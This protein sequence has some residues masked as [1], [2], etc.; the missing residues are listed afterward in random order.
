MFHPAMGWVWGN[1]PLP[2]GAVKAFR[3]LED[4]GGL[5]DFVG[6]TRTKYVPIDEQVDL[7]LG[8]DLEVRIQPKLMNWEKLDLRFDRDGNVSGWTIRETWEVEL[9]N[10]RE[11]PVTVDIRR[12]FAGDWTIESRQAYEMIDAG[13]V[14]FELPLAAG[15][16]KSFAYA[17]TTNFGANV[18]R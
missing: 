14:K 7:E 3:V 11:I 13:K 9:Q 12:N 4:K 1:E 2:D 6:D 16:K 18:R 15:E 10:S 17:V 8:N 5:Y